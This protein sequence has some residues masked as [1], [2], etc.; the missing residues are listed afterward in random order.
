MRLRIREGCRLSARR[1]RRCGH[2]WFCEGQNITAA[3][4]YRTHP[5]VPSCG[6]MQWIGSRFERYAARKQRQAAWVATIVENAGVGKN[7]PLLEVG[8]GF[9]FALAELRARGFQHLTGVE[10]DD[11]ARAYAEERLRLTMRV[12]AEQTLKRASGTGSNVLAVHWLEHCRDPFALVSLIANVL[13][14]KGKAIV[15]VPNGWHWKVRLFEINSFRRNNVFW[16]LAHPHTFSAASLRA[17]GQR[18]GLD[19]VA[20]YTSSFGR[21][22]YED[23]PFVRPVDRVLDRFGLGRD[24]VAV[25]RQLSRLSGSRAK[26]DSQVVRAAEGTSR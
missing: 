11:G 14:D 24:A 20:G 4:Y 25:F 21:G 12:S 3:D 13:A 8:T 2:I 18:S 26:E 19:A 7:E 5:E 1:C 10:E 16:K 22:C 17:L 9:G 23:F 15:V 6:P